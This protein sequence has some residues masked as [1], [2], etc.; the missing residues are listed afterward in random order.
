MEETP[1]F[2]ARDLFAPDTM[3]DMESALSQLSTNREHL[4]EFL[5][6]ARYASQRLRD[7][8][9]HTE[10]VERRTSQ[11]ARARETLR[12]HDRRELVKA[13][14]QLHEG[15]TPLPLE[16]AEWMVWLR[17]IITAGVWAGYPSDVH[18]LCRELGE[19]FGDTALEVWHTRSAE[20]RNEDGSFPDPVSTE[21][22]IAKAWQGYWGQ[23]QHHPS[24]PRLAEGWATIWRLAKRSGLCDVWD[25]MAEQLGVPT[26][27][28]TQSGEVTVS[29]TFSAT[30]YVEGVTDYDPDISLDD[31]LANLDRYSIEIDEIDTDNL[32]YE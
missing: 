22:A 30:I 13:L 17:V 25:V 1:R 27:E 18:N 10:K 2:T 14:G 12:D 28:L 26:T 21:E 3:P 4:E 8:M 29:G 24:D 31:V 7:R 32:T 16:H 11:V 19:S 20:L 5:N 15:A 23:L 6:E 9:E